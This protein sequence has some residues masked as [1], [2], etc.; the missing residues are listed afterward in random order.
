MKKLMFFVLAM[1]YTAT[2]WGQTGEVYTKIYE[3]SATITSLGTSA[4]S[5]SLL[6][7]PMES[8]AGIFLSIACD[9]ELSGD[10]DMYL[11]DEDLDD[12]STTGAWY[13]AT[14]ISMETKLAFSEDG[15]TTGWRDDSGISFSCDD[16]TY[17]KSLYM[18]VYN[19]SE[20]ATDTFN[21]K[22]RYRKYPSEDL[23]NVSD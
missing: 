17:T 10:F 18:G 19:A 22:F 2:S 16:T 15:S 23:G 11:F 7:I 1:L 9:N 20:S 13:T 8:Q 6:R 21:C 14:N 4:P 12:D 5:S 3:R